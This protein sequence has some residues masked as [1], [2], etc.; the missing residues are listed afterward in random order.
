[1]KLKDWV[2]FIALGLVWGSSYY[3]IKVAV[4]ELGPYTLVAFRLLFGT[5][6][7]LVVL[8]WHRPALPRDR[9]TWLILALI[10]IIHTW[11]PF[12]LISWSEQYIDSGM[13]SILNSTVP[14]F[15]LVIARFFLQDERLERGQIVGLLI[16]FAGV[17]VLM[18]HDVGYKLELTYLLGKAAV[19]VAA[20]AYAGSSVFIRKMLRPVS[21]IVQAAASVAVANGLAWTAIPWTET[22][23]RVPVL[24]ETWLALAW[25]GLLGSCVAYL[26]YFYLIHAV[27]PTRTTMVT[28]VMPVVGIALGVYF[29]QELLSWSIAVGAVLTG[30]GVYVVNR[31]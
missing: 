1:M 11:V 5:L 30:L 8:F 20:V 18:S 22:P 14:L 31:R 9:R 4:H 26:L 12:V 29:M 10:G 17:I 24:S 6:G 16:G 13:A 19:L 28:Y 21:P 7:L 23:F 27:G 2:T 3:W 25:L 15:T